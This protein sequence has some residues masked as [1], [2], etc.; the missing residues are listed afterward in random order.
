M[1][2]WVI[3]FALLCA[4]TAW[5]QYTPGVNGTGTTVELPYA[6]YQGIHNASTG[7]DFFLC[8]MYAKVPVGK[9][10]FIHVLPFGTRI[11]ASNAGYAGEHKGSL[12]HRIR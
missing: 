3:S 11:L 5:T 7:L 12:P 9:S 1:E 8:I 6:R 10:G 2:I 4:P